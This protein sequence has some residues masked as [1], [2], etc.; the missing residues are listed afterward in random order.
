MRTTVRTEVSCRVGVAGAE[1]RVLVLA[2]DTR[3]CVGIDLDSGAF[4]RASYS[5]SPTDSFSSFDVVAGRIAASSLPPDA[6][7]PETVSLEEPPIRCGRLSERRA[8]R[9]ID[10]LLHPRR[11]PLLGFAGRAVPYWTLAG[12]RPSLSIV[13]IASGPQLRRD[14]G[15]YECRFTWQGGRHQYALGDRRLALQLEDAGWPRFSSRD[16]QRLLGYRVRRLLIVLTPP[17]EGYCYKVVAAL[18][19]GS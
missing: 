17:Q 15:G 12:D 8:E 18:L 14:A 1:L 10:S 5:A 6:S 2:A 7:R 11:G 19:P 13:D 3:G 16:L 4:V 9:Y